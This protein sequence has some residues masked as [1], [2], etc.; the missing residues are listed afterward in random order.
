M[1]MPQGVTAFVDRRAPVAARYAARPQGKTLLKT[2]LS[3]SACS[4]MTVFQPWP[5]PT[6]RESGSDAGGWHA[7]P[8]APPH[9]QV[10]SLLDEAAR[11]S[12]SARKEKTRGCSNDTAGAAEPARAERSFGPRRSNL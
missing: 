1:Q 8:V 3:D 7:V 9:V 5:T 4:G 6:D 10:D 2:N 12:L 11:A